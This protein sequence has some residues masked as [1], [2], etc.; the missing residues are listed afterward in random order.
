MNNDVALNSE[1]RR[2]Q[3]HYAPALQVPLMPWKAE[4]IFKEYVYI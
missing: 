1:R 3:P 2:I 4:I